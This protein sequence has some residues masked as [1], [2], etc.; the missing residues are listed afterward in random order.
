MEENG[1]VHAAFSLYQDYKYQTYI[2]KYFWNAVQMKLVKHYVYVQLDYLSIEIDLKIFF[3]MK[4]YL[5]FILLKTEYNTQ[6][7]E[8]S[9]LKYGIYKPRVQV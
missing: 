4:I 6:S 2:E 5:N 7:I 9:N 1:W 8:S 3:F